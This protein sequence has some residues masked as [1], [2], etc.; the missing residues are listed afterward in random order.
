MQ[1]Q[2]KPEARV[3]VAVFLTLV[4]VIVIVTLLVGGAPI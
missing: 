4:S 2:S 3:E 1:D